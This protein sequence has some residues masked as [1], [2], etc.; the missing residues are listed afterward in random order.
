MYYISILKYVMNESVWICIHAQ[1][2]R[3][4]IGVLIKH[5]NRRLWV[6]AHTYSLLPKIIKCHDHSC[7][8]IVLRVPQALIPKPLWLLE[9][10][11][12]IR[13]PCLFLGPAL[14]SHLWGG[15]EMGPRFW[16]LAKTLR[17]FLR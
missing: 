16:H 3:S 15:W 2:S 6:V 7:E 4:Q 14:P 8:C 12:P 1:F 17:D 5:W 9:C 13:H 10:L 11:H